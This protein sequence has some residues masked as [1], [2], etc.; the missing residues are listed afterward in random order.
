VKNWPLFYLIAKNFKRKKFF[1]DA[2]AFFPFKKL[3]FL[4]NSQRK[5][6]VIRIL[7]VYISRAQIP[8]Q[9]KKKING[10]GVH[11]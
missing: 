4:K 2:G 6:N 11:L 1:F 8:L 5:D 3:R 7:P 10:V 9:N